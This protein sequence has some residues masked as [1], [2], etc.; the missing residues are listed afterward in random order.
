MKKIKIKKRKAT[1]IAYI[2]HT[3]DYSSIPYEES[4]SKLY[5][6]AKKNKI[7]PGFKPFAV[8]PDDPNSGLKENIRTRIA[9]S[10]NKLVQDSETILSVELPEMQVATLKFSGSSD[11]YQTAYNE[12]WKWVKDNG[13]A[14]SGSPIEI[15]GKKPKIENGK[16]IIKSEIQAPITKVN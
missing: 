11:E 2:E 10:V 1:K 12:L 9:I 5:S 7:R 13:Y 14:L 8:Y 4:I 16:S 3:G 6:F 15:W